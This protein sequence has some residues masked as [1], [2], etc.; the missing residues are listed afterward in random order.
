MRC[1]SSCVSSRYYL[2]HECLASGKSHTLTVGE[3]SSFVEISKAFKVDTTH[4]SFFGVRDKTME[5]L[6][7]LDE[8]K[9]L[10]STDHFEHA[11]YLD[12]DTIDFVD[13]VDG[14]AVEAQLAEVY[15]LEVY[16]EE[17][18]RAEQVILDEA[19]ARSFYAKEE[20]KLLNATDYDLDAD[21]DD[22]SSEFPTDY[23]K[24]ALNAVDFATYEQ[25]LKDRDWRSLD[26]QS[27]R[28]YTN[29]V[30]QN[31]AV[32]CPGC[33]VGVQKVMGCNH[34]TCLNGHQFCFLCT[35]KWKTCACQT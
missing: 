1:Y 18:R 3:E 9:E 33:G 10:T 32:Q 4:F 16:R 11:V 19:V 29:V 13:E 20:H 2:L 7:K 30:R 24:E 22:D 8:L 25:F 34:M 31:H 23:V 17:I 6:P 5:V 15:A 35:S 12:S 21:S 14:E 27:D 28:D 26:L